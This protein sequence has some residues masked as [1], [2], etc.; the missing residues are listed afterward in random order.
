MSFGHVWRLRSSGLGLDVSIELETA[1]ADTVEFLRPQ[2]PLCGAAC[3]GGYAGNEIYLIAPLLNP[4]PPTAVTENLTVVP[5]AT[6]VIAW[7]DPTRT[8]IEIGLFYDD[9][10]LLVSPRWGFTPVSVIGRAR[11]L[12]ADHRERGAA[13]KQQIQRADPGAFQL[14]L[15]RAESDDGTAEG[16]AK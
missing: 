12:G 16:G 11:G 4:P 6:E 7:V 9:H 3:A 1:A 10:N 5:A 8:L 2:L 14:E 15:S 13:W